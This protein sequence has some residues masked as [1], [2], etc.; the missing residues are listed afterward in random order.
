MSYWTHIVAIIEVDTYKQD[1]NIKEIVENML[2]SAPKITGSE[3]DADIFVNVLSGHNVW[4]GADCDHCQYKDTIVYNDNGSFN[5]DADDNYKCPEGE[6][7]TRVII[8]VVGNLRDRM[9]EQTKREYKE[10]YN[11]LK[12]TCVFDINN[13]AVSILGY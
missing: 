5:C 1:K 10:F 2:K 9:R 3:R 8:T 13:K 6:Y 11:Y 7:Q 12:K 4:M